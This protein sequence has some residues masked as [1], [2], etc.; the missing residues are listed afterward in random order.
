MYEKPILSDIVHGKTKYEITAKYRSSPKFCAKLKAAAF[1]NMLNFFNCDVVSE[2]YKFVC[3]KVVIQ[4]QKLA[5]IVID[6]S[7]NQ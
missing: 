1:G 2:R 4:L 3:K 6:F 5:Q 7:G